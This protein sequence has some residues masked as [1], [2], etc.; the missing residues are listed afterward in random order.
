MSDKKDNNKGFTAI[1][2]GSG[3][4]VENFKAKRNIVVTDDLS[5]VDS[6]ISVG[7]NSE[8]INLDA[9][10]NEVHTPESY[11]QKLKRDRQDFFEGLH[12][13]QADINSIQNDIVAFKIKKEL[14]G[15]QNQPMTAK[16]EFTFKKILGNILSMS[17]DVG[18]GV[19]TAVI[20]KYLGY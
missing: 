17:K 3:S 2:I 10:G 11:K 16:G 6:I 8:I 5:I 14:V 9:D 7:D 13:I 15:A 12:E 4:K 1:R 18:C 20:T 19:L